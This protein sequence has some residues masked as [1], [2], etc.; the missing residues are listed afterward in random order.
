MAIV[1][2]KF[3]EVL[4][5]DSGKIF[6][7]RQSFSLS[8]KESDGADNIPLRRVEHLFTAPSYLAHGA[9][10]WPD[11]SK[12]HPDNAIWRIVGEP[13]DLKHWTLES[14]QLLF[15]KAGNDGL[16][17]AAIWIATGMMLDRSFW[18]H[19]TAGDKDT[20][21]WG[22][23]ILGLEWSDSPRWW[24]ALGFKNSL[25]GGRFCGQ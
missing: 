23:R 2:S 21:R 6:L 14:G 24:S 10:F 22:M 8:L 25:E 9:V 4:Y 20:F 15:N 19:M 16:N 1:Q 18:F 11:L 5:L 12:D 13:C 7:Y 3:Q 17:L